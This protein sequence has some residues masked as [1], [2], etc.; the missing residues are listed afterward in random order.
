MIH[1]PKVK[2]QKRIN[3]I[4]IYIE[5]ERERERAPRRGRLIRCKTLR[6]VFFIIR[7]C[8]KVFTTETV[9]L[10]PPKKDTLIF[11][12]FPFFLVLIYC[13]LLSIDCAILHG[14]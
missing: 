10:C 4:Y 9:K 11:Q 12:C 13:H 8:V 6:W 7:I 3:N 5:R 2:L 14:V 1:H